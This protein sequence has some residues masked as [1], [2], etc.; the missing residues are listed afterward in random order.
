MTVSLPTGGKVMG[1]FVYNV[2]YAFQEN[3]KQTEELNSSQIK[4]ILVS[5]YQNV[6]AC[7]KLYDNYIESGFDVH[8]ML[9]GIFSQAYQNIAAS[10]SCS[11]D[12]ESCEDLCELDFM[13]QSAEGI[14]MQPSDESNSA[15]EQNV[16][17]SDPAN[18]VILSIRMI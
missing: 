4:E 1:L 11:Y 2:M 14:S 6:R 16:G 10:R 9:E 7:E 18:N 5:F 15:Q 13:V 8:N 3:K 12:C 17:F